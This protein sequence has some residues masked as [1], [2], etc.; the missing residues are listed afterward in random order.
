MVDGLRDRIVEEYHMSRYS[1]H[2]G[3]MKMYHELTKFYCLKGMKKDIAQ[4]VA[5]GPN[6]Q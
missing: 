3:S 4:F 5:N 6:C 2:R 1:I